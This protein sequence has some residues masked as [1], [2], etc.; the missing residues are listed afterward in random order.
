MINQEHSSRSCTSWIKLT[1]QQTFT[2]WVDGGTLDT[3]VV[4]TM[5]GSAAVNNASQIEVIPEILQA[6]STLE[7]AIGGNILQQLNNFKD[8][9]DLYETTDIPMFWHIPKAGGSSIMVAMGGR[10][11]LLFGPDQQ[12]WCYRWTHSSHSNHAFLIPQC[13][14]WLTRIVVHLLI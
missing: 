7:I 1:A 14:A 13:L 2:Q 4:G 12:I 11:V 3:A 5:S 9:W 8:S 10:W 6:P